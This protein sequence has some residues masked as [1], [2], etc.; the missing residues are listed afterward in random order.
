MTFNKNSVIIIMYQ[1]RRATP[2]SYGA[3]L[4][5]RKTEIMVGLVQNTYWAVNVSIQNG[6]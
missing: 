2:G 6:P 4:I 1:G 5:A 3:W